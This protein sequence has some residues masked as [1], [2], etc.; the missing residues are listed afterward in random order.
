MLQDMALNMKRV[1]LGPQGRLVVP[2][3]LR[4]ELG[5]QPGDDLVAWVEDGRL[6]VQTREQTER[7]IHDMVAHVKVSLV[8]ELIR[9]RRR[10]AAREG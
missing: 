8:D 1:R 6:I 2:A 7:E 4:E 9:E 10:E 3:D 5:V